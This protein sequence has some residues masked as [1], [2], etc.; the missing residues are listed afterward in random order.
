ML[1]ACNSVFMFKY[2][3]PPGINS[4]SAP[5]QEEAAQYPKMRQHV[6]VEYFF[7]GFVA[8]FGQGLARH[9]AGVVHQHGY[10]SDFFFHLSSAVQNFLSVRHV[11]SATVNEKKLIKMLMSTAVMM[12]FN[13]EKCF[14]I[15]LTG[16][17]Y[18]SVC[19]KMCVDWYFK[20]TTNCS[21]V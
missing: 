14:F 19:Y 10:I 13:T 11:H 3:A 1:K 4:V 12:R 17:I 6:D 15:H 7:Y 5:A 21:I 18:K 2:N 20:K 9:D 8:L 16:S